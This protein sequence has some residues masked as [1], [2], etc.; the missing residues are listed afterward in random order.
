[1]S[2]SQLKKRQ[3]REIALQVLFQREY[4]PNLDINKSLQL[5]HELSPFSEKT[6]K[7]AQILCS[8]VFSQQEAID[9][10]IAEASPQ[11]HLDRMAM[12]DLNILRLACL[13]LTTLSEKIPPKVAIDEAIEI[14]KKYGTKDSPRFINGILD[15][16]CKHHL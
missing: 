9:K 15:E 12:V 8:G 10:K 4:A 13:E 1:M 3:A 16:I 6:Q 7:Y 5:L 11:W 14:A 2:T